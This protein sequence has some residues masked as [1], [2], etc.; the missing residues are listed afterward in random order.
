LSDLK[1]AA[2]I[3]RLLYYPIL[4]S[5]KDRVINITPAVH[6]QMDEAGWVLIFEHICHKHLGLGKP[7]IHAICDFRTRLERFEKDPV[8]TMMIP[9]KKEFAV[10]LR[11]KSGQYTL[12][13]RI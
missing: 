6:A 9:M 3:E 10:I 1:Q 7:S 13:F 5:Y 4:Q 2:M 11:Q 8:D 12:E